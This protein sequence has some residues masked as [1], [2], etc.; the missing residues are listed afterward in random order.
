M[1]IWNACLRPLECLRSPHHRHQGNGATSLT[2]A[3]QRNGQR[4][5]HPENGGK[6]PGLASSQSKLTLALSGVLIT[7]NF[8]SFPDKLQ[9]NI[10]LF[11]LACLWTCLQA[12][13]SASGC[14]HLLS[15]ISLF[16]AVTHVN[17]VTEAER[18]CVSD[19]KKNTTTKMKWV[20]YL[21]AKHHCENENSW[22]HLLYLS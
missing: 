1:R 9:L 14:C 17:K 6:R 21:C 18:Q 22:I 8:Q 2:G 12:T 15:N 11:P 10:M 4:G 16:P 7:W 20:Q 13:N 19:K 3:G 5:W